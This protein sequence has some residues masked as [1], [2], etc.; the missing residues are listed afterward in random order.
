MWW[1]AYA[2]AEGFYTLAAWVLEPH[3][4]LYF[5]RM[6]LWNVAAFAAWEAGRGI[7]KVADRHY[8]TA[9]RAFRA[10]DQEGCKLALS[11]LHAALCR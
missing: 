8:P 7:R 4:S 11:N 9:F 3:V 2:Q 10:W 1:S 6:S 5:T